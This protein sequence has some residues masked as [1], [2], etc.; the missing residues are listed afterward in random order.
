MVMG[1]WMRYRQWQEALG[2]VEAATMPHHERSDPDEVFS[3]WL[4]ERLLTV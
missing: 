4:V 2:L 1:P 3:V